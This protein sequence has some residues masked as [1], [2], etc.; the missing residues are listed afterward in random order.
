MITKIYNRLPNHLKECTN[1]Q[2]M[3]KTRMK[4]FLI[5]KVYYTLEEYFN[6]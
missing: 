4:E 2:N 3:F 1:N 6:N 5:N